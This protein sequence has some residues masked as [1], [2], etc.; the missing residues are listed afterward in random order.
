MK[1]HIRL[2]YFLG[3]LAF[4]IVLT[5]FGKSDDK[6][7]QPPQLIQ[8]LLKKERATLN[9]LKTHPVLR[10]K[11]R[12][13]LYEKLGKPAPTKRR[14]IRRMPHRA[15]V[16]LPPYCQLIVDNNIFRPLG[17]REYQW[18][19]K[20]E[21]IGT[22]VYADSAKNT[23]ILKSNHP[24]YRRLIVQTGDTFLEELIMTRIEARQIIYSDENGKQKHLN[25]PSLFGG[26]TEKLETEDPYETFH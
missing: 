25:L 13:Q 4:M 18:T 15:F 24:K 12:Q 19:L 8:D 23:A 11:L 2:L 9:D 7:P 1:Q 14:R 20:L 26:G 10:E 21:L 17:Y 16:K 3:I 6:P 22:M 5:A